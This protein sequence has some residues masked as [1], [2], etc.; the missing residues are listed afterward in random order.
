MKID[1]SNF[2]KSLKNLE[3]QHYRYVNMPPDYP[4]WVQEGIA[5]SVIQRFE[6][7]F[8]TLWKV[9]RHHLI[10]VLGIPEVPNSPRPIFRIADQNSLLAAGGAQWEVYVQT[11]IDTSH[12]YSEEKA[13][14]ALA[15]IPSFVG[16]AIRL[17]CVMAGEV[18]K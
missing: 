7:C 13:G 9:L 1:Y 12:D 15:V 10:G 16:D 18:W 17:Y 2:S 6:T 8:D 11:R 4:G 14:R 3:S 5:E